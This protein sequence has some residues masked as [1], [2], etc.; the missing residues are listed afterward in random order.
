MIFKSDSS[1]GDLNGFLDRGSRIQGE[2]A[3]ETTFRVDGTV[4]GTVNSQ[5]DLV[6]GEGGTVDGEVQVGQLFVSGTVKGSVKAQRKVHVAPGGRVLADL[7]TPALIVEDGAV[8]EGRCTM[9]RK[10][11]AR[12]QGPAP[13]PAPTPAPKLVAQGRGPKGP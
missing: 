12:D 11:Q 8:L 4:E 3:F 6:V 10:G 2:L 9:S 1:T 13:A 7:E 5:G